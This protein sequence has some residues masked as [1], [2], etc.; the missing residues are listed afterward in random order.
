ML[1][2]KN[3]AKEI[4]T[5]ETVYVLYCWV[6]VDDKERE[7]SAIVVWSEYYTEFSWRSG[8]EGI[9][10]EDLEDLEEEMLDKLHNN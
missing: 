8:W 9:S 6:I 1:E 3:F 10:D 2:I 4:K 5:V 7:I